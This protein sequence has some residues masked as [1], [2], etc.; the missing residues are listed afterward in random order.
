MQMQ[1]ELDQPIVFKYLDYRKY[2]EDM[3]HY[4]KIK[5]GSS[6]SYRSFSMRA[7]L[8]SPNYL[9]L[10]MGGQRELT[11]KTIQKFGKGFDLNKEELA[12]FEALV[13]F[14]KSKT[15]EEKEFY[16]SRLKGL[17]QFISHQNITADQYEY[18]SNWYIPV[19]REM[20]L[21]KGFKN[22]PSWV[23]SHIKPRITSHE[24]KKAIE[25]LLR[26]GL[27][28]EHDGVM[29]QSES[30]L[31]T[32]NEIQSM[33]IWNFHNNMISLA[34]RSL[35]E[36]TRE[37][38]IAGLT[39]ALNK[40]QFERLNEMVHHFFMESQKMSEEEVIAERV[41]QLNVQLFSLS[42]KLKDEES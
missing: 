29:V 9:K 24:A 27:L 26:L 40:E 34:Q 14:N 3:Y 38:N 32:G 16:F 13:L 8:S 1:D 35:K 12:F 28:A 39:I 10:V 42:K 4:Q 36:T 25:L 6:F 23:A 33:A 20:V 2:L 19:I 7:G 17:K 18:F 15:N 30:Q 11:Q 37:R 5:K 31:N 21:L 22:D 41:Y